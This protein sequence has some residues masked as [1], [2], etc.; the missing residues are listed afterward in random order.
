L[1]SRWPYRS[2]AGTIGLSAGPRGKN[3]LKIGSRFVVL[4]DLSI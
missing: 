4:A 2:S 1:R 3:P